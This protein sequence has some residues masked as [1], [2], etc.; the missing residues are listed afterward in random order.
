MT[1]RGKEREREPACKSKEYR[2]SI[3]ER[4]R[5]CDCTRRTESGGRNR[6]AGSSVY[7]RAQ[8]LLLA[9]AKPEGFTNTIV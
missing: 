3:G 8:S 4:P 1:E 6:S 9:R 2:R 5:P 7:Y